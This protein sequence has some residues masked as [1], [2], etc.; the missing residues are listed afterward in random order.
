MCLEITTST[1]P[2]EM[3]VL[4]VVADQIMVEFLPEKGGDI[5]KICINGNNILWESPWGI[6]KLG[7]RADYCHTSQER[8]LQN[9]PGGWQ[10][11]FP[12]AGDDSLYN[13]VTYNYHG[14]ACQVP[15][16]YEILDQTDFIAVIKFST[17]LYKTPYSIERIVTI[18]VT[19]QS[20][21]VKESITNNGEQDLFVEWGQHI[22]FGAP[23]IGPGTTL[24]VPAKM[25]ESAEQDK[26][27]S[28]LKKGIH[29]W[30]I[31]DLSSDLSVVPS[32]KATD[33]AILKD[34][35]RGIYSINNRQLDLSVVVEWNKEI[36]SNVWLWQEFNGLKN[37]PFYGACYVMG[38][39]PNS[40]SHH[41]G[42]S[43]SIKRDEA[44]EIKAQETKTFDMKLSWMNYKVQELNK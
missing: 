4:Q 17:R 16:R 34:L 15:W 42:L 12:N 3:E 30:P 6:W 26:V 7:N 33:F 24:D 36:L 25:I 10:L 27:L 32:D 9:Y 8:W 41:E 35:D 19:N 38:V 39:E 18:D 23:L 14:E 29:T 40:A 5:Y 13:G 20:L 1:K 11:M 37:Y 31:K 28:R 43:E 21:S 22:A 2:G 44:I